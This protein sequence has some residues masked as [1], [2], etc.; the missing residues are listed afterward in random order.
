MD[1]TVSDLMDRILDEPMQV[2]L[3]TITQHVTC[4]DALYSLVEKVG[5]TM[6]HEMACVY[7]TDDARIACSSP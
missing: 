3:F 6:P 7:L 4:R 2:I 5:Q 1:K